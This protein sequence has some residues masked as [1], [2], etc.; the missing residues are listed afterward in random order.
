M[1]LYIE[2]YGR[3][4]CNEPRQMMRVLS[5]P[6]GTRDRSLYFRSGVTNTKFGIYSLR[7]S[8]LKCTEVTNQ[9]PGFLFLFLGG[10][11]R[12]RRSLQTMLMNDF[13]PHENCTAARIGGRVKHF[14]IPRFRII[15]HLRTTWLLQPE[16]TL[17]TT[18]VYSKSSSCSIYSSWRYVGIRNMMIWYRAS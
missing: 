15:I 8:S 7:L 12:Y 1:S 16:H 2:E 4:L 5:L 18:R 11:M 3:R 13:I 14:Q 17:S 6:E 9:S 10:I